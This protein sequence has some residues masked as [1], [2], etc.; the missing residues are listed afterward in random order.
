MCPIDDVLE[1]ANKALDTADKA[2]DTAER[3]EKVCDRF[4]SKIK[5]IIRK[6][7]WWILAAVVICFIAFAFFY[8]YGDAVRT[9]FCK[10]PDVYIRIFEYGQDGRMYPFGQANKVEANG[11][12]YQ[13]DENGEVCLPKHSVDYIINNMC[14]EGYY[15]KKT[16]KH[17]NSD[18]SRYLY[19]EAVKIP[20]HAKFSSPAPEAVA[21][22]TEN[23]NFMVSLYDLHSNEIHLKKGE[24][25]LLEPAK[26]IISIPLEVNDPASTVGHSL[27]FSDIGIGAHVATVKYFNEI[28]KPSPSKLSD[29]KYIIK[30]KFQFN[31]NDVDIKKQ[32][33][34]T[35]N[36]NGKIF[37]R[38]KDKQPSEV[39]IFKNVDFFKQHKIELVYI[40]NTKKSIAF[41]RFGDITIFI[42]NYEK[43]S[44]YM[45]IPNNYISASL[46]RIEMQKAP[47][48]QKQTR[49][50]A[51]CTPKVMD[52]KIN[53]LIKIQIENLGRTPLPYYFLV[54]GDTQLHANHGIAFGVIED[55]SSSET[56]QELEFWNTY[57]Y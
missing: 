55:G 31:K 52:S 50:V 38:S 11:E 46:D 42:Q 24:K 17:P 1:L 47:E 53:Y 9:F 36:K 23:I 25:I 3:F 13:L 12:I 19:F 34:I 44:I 45:S 20:M 54:E 8:Y 37:L 57:A 30:E 41:V 32:R 29:H 49:L 5:K 26:N 6:F 51:E 10:A 56:L 35:Q 40:P 43:G 21:N 14:S 33:Y 39:Q 7:L 15:I 28:K 22:N 4:G 27:K 16:E 48:H 18:S 2:M